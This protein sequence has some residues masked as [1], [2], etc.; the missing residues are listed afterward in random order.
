MCRRRL[1]RGVDFARGDVPAHHVLDVVDDQIRSGVL[2]KIKIYDLSGLTL[3]S[4]G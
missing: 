2:T 4:T 3:F 1:Q